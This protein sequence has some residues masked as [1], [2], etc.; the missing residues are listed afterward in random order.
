[1]MI[2]LLLPMVNLVIRSLRWEGQ[3]SLINYQLLATP[4]EGFAGGVSVNEAL[5]HSLSIAADATII[6]LIIGLPLAYVLSRRVGGVAKIIQ[7]IVDGF[8]L[9]PLGVSTVT[10]GFGMLITLG[11]GPMAH[12]PWLVP[13]AQS[14]VALP[15]VIRA[16]VPVVRA[17]DPDMRSAAA[18][19][20]ASPLRVVVT[21]DLP[22]AWRG[23]ILA[24]GF[25]FSTS[26]GEFGATSFLARPDFQTLPVLIVKL[27]GRPGEHNYGMALAGAVVLAVIVGGVMMLA[28]ICAAREPQRKRRRKGVPDEC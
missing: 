16:I 4:G 11:F 13:I 22:L 9:L 25:A 5:M 15:L 28:E 3:W 23:V 24:F 14:I 8:V 20:G 21:V 10:V 7:R 18:S 12:S 1:M 26:L 2:F 17:I 27:L 6:A 19:L